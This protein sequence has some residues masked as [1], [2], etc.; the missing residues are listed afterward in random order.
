MSDDTNLEVETTQEPVTEP[1]T[2]PVVEPVT[3]PANV[4]PTSEPLTVGQEIVAEIKELEDW[5]KH[6]LFKEK[7]SA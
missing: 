4:T 3:A 1:V 5:L 2:E 7:N 6:K